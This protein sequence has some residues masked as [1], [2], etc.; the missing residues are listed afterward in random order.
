MVETRLNNQARCL[1]LTMT[2]MMIH[3]VMSCRGQEA[4][5]SGRCS[6][7]VVESKSKTI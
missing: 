1:C 3:E 7:I 5:D 2:T 6:S 4:M